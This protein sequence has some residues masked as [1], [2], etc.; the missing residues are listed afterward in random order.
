MVMTH[1][2]VVNTDDLEPS[3]MSP[4][5]TGFRR[6]RLSR[7]TGAQDLGCSLYS[8]AP[9]AASWPYHFHTGNEE[10]MF[11]LEG[12]GVVR[13]DGTE[14][15][16]SPGDFVTL[17]RGETGAHRVY[18]DGEKPFRYL[19]ISTMNEPDIAVYPEADMVG[20]FAGAAPGGRP[21]QRGLHAFLDA[22]A[23]VAYWEATSEDPREEAEDPSDERR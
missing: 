15:T 22:S 1:P 8:L 10:A 13:L 21:S 17:P 4:D 19:C 23:E 5:E 9:D 14:L 11:V 7:A 12:T 3:D 6:K 16:V 2:H 18:N 20:L